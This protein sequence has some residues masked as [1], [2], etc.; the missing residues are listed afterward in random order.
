MLKL[1]S[2]FCK[3]AHNVVP[4][5]TDL[6]GAKNMVSELQG[7][8]HEVESKAAPV[9]GEVKSGVDAATTIVET[10]APQFAPEAA[11]ADA[12]VDKVANAVKS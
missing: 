9:V 3:R 7:W 11:A 1:F 8:I 2:F 6:E 12:V 5:V 10:V 4:I